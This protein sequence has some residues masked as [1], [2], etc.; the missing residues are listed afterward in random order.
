VREEERR[1]RGREGW[2]I[3]LLTNHHYHYDHYYDHYYDHLIKT[4]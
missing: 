3:L 1:E 2:N 4:K